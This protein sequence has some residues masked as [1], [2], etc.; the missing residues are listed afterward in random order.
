MTSTT[1]TA[2]SKLKLNNPPEFNG[3]YKQY[4]IWIRKVE[5]FL[6]GNKV[7][8]DEEKI[9]VT[10]SFMTTG[11]ALNW[12]QAFTDDALQRNDFGTWGDF[13]NKLDQ[14]FKDQVTKE[15]T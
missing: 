13:K 10:L 15:K 5:L 8:K 14:H 2:S 12:C 4:R 9:L 3:S 11:P 1:S 6:Q 7:S